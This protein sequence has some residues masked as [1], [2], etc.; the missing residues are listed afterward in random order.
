M[1]RTITFKGAPLTLVGRSITEGIPAPFFRVH[2]QDMKEVTLSDNKNKIRLVSVFPSLDTPVCDL[3]VKEF[4][5]RAL[6]LGK[7]VLVINISKDLPFAQQRFCQMN[8]ITDSLTL[9]DYRFS[10]FG[11]NYGLLIKEL[12]LLARAVLIIDAA[13]VI[14]YIQ[15]ADEL[16]QALQYDAALKNLE[17]IVKKPAAAIPQDTLP[18]HCVA[19]EGKVPALPPKKI[20]EL[21]AEYRGWKCMEAKK[22]TKEFFHKDFIEAKYFVDLLALIAEEQG[23]HPIITLNYAKVTVSLTTHSAGGLTEND[24][25][26]AKIIDKI[27]TGAGK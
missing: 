8:T 15:L 10:S 5:K 27:G 24:F 4:N 26:M 19:C 7:N 9:S 2:A 17:N 18:A 14:R 6:G 20:E 13:D 12:N 22:L 3:Q 1:K 21:L 25:I 11:L 16:T 23:H